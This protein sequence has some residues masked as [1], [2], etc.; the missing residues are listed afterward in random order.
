V[1][2]HIFRKDWKLIW[3]MAAG[4]AALNV[5]DRY[6][7]WH[8]AG[9]PWK[10]SNSDGLWSMLEFVSFVSTALLIAVVVHQDALPGVRQDWL[11]R[12]I[13]RRDL[14]AS[15]L[16]FM[17]LL[18]QGPIF[19]AEFSVPALAGMPLGPSLGTA[20]GRSIWMLV[21]LDVPVLALASVTRN[22]VEAI[23]AML[24][25]FLGFLALVIGVPNNPFALGRMGV[26]W[27]LDWMQASW[28]LVGAAVVLTLMYRWRKTVRARWV[29]AAGAALWPFVQLIPWQAAFAVEE[30]LSPQPAAASPIQIAFDPAPG[31]RPSGN[32]TGILAL[33]N[34]PV[35]AVSLALPLRIDGVGPSQILVA[36]RARL[37]W[38]APGGQAIRIEPEH[39]FSFFRPD[40]VNYQNLLIPLDAYTPI[41]DQHLRL[42]IDYSLTLLAAG[43]PQSVPAFSGDRWISDFGRCKTELGASGRDVHLHCV[44]PSL[45]CAEFSIESPLLGHTH[46]F[47]S[48]CRPDYDPLPTRLGGDAS[49]DSVL[50]VMPQ[51]MDPAQQKQTR[52]LAAVYRPE[53]HFTRRLVIPDIRLSDWSVE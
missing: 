27:V 42:E 49:F 28:G 4:V 26:D 25:L 14:L 40:A 33:R 19:L 29:F 24:A 3:R 2:W 13:R 6:V 30:R 16:L 20:L 17:A 21:F 43:P 31:K 48:A 35:R 5:I 45:L 50:L 52:L 32:P 7:R 53:V 47:R 34:R 8:A 41:K 10:P 18:V 23:G 11:V 22:L 36:D 46:P 9:M 15:K 12:P 1:V 38:F 44:S 37:H 39:T 51:P